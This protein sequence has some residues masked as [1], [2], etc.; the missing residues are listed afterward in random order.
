[1]SYRIVPLGEAALTVR[2]G[3]TLDEATHAQ[4]RALDTALTARPFAGMREIVPAFAAVTVFY[5]PLLLGESEARQYIEAAI[6][7]MK[8]VPPEAGR[9]V[10]VPVLYGGE[11]GPDLPAVAERNGLAPEE[12]IE[13]HSSG[14]Y[15][16]YMIGFAPG[17]PY[18]GGMSERIAAPRRDTPRL[19]VPAGSVGIAGAQTGIYSVDSPGGWQVIGRTPLRLFTPERDPPSLLRAGDRVRF[20]PVT[21]E[22]YAA[23]E[24]EESSL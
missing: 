24:I 2:F 18:L 1:M 10:E 13:I 21:P 23:R 5:D 20:Q 7:D 15:L 17:F 3:E 16:I 12:V 8:P 4:V 11:H 6:S 14:D 19:K 22:E 9:T